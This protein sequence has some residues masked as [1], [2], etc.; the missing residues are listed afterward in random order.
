MP[1]I[2]FSTPTIFMACNEIPQKMI[3]NNQ[4]LICAKLLSIFDI[5]LLSVYNM[6]TLHWFLLDRTW[7]LIIIKAM[8]RGINVRFRRHASTQWEKYEKSSQYLRNKSMRCDADDEKIKILLWDLL[9]SH[10][11]FS[12]KTFDL[13]W[14]YCVAMILFCK[15]WENFY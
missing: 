11:I 12:A 13:F 5:F 3:K 10:S 6:F 1:T 4:T 2:I 7:K 14:K 9:N 15:E 8:M